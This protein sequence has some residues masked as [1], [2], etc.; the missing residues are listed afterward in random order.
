VRILTVS[1][2]FENHGGGIERVAAQLNREFSRAGHRAIWSACGADDIAD[3]FTRVPL[4]CLDPAR[5]TTG[6]PL[7][8]PRFA[9]LR[10]LF[11]A[12]RDS[13]AVIIHDSLYLTS[14]A[15]IIAAKIRGKPVLLIQHI[16]DIQ[17]KGSAKRSLM[18]LANLC[19]TRPMLAAADHL[20]F[21]SDQVRRKLVGDSPRRKYVLLYNGVNSSVFFPATRLSRTSVRSR[22]E[23]PSHARV[24]LFVGRFVEKKGLGILKLVAASR[25]DL[26]F[27]LVGAGPISPQSWGFEN[28]RVFAMQSPQVVAD[29]YRAAD[30]LL[31]PSVG[32]GFPLVIQEAMACGLPVVCNTDSAAADPH[33]SQWLRGIELHLADEVGSAA[34]CDAA[35]SEALRNPIDTAQMARYAVHSYSWTLMAEKLAGLLSG[36]T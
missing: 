2:F 34:L 5:K 33:A 3:E 13:E 14:I 21:I 32:E 27:F 26:L 22:Y 8:I 4:N 10:A 25:P 35:I 12:V 1:H 19:V 31:L 16:A 29:L 17:F 9:A 23:I 18:W 6:L 15:A 11:R 28:V 7:P 20:V 30:L 36:R 24:V